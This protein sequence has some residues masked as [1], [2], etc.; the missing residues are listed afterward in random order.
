MKLL[1]NLI[2][3][4]IFLSSLSGCASFGKKLKAFLSKDQAQDVEGQQVAPRPNLGTKYSDV[5]TFVQAPRRKY[6]RMTK[7]DFEKG[8]QLACEAGSLWI[9][10]G[11][12]SYL[13]SQNIIRMVG[14]PIAVKIEGDPKD[15]LESKMQ[16]IDKLLK[17]LEARRAAVARQLASQRKAQVAGEVA[18]QPQADPEPTPAP[19]EGGAAADKD[20]E[21]KVK[22]VPARITERLVDGNYRIK[23]SQPF[24]IGK[25]EY[26]AIVTGI[27]RPEDFSEEG[28]S[29]KK[30]IDPRFDIVSSRGKEPES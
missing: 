23:G 4:L 21:F 17:K 1:I 6:Q 29:A 22:F 20:A 25:K 8:S 14:D 16:V 7:E 9:M 26:L 5:Q 30:L 27:V 13:F 15:Q 28:I 11:Q 2:L 18:T 19:E 24:L 10:E 3:A 12:G